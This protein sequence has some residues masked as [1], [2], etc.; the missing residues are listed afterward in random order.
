MYISSICDFILL[1]DLE[2]EQATVSECDRSNN[3]TCTK[4]PLT[5]ACQVW[6]VHSVLYYAEYVHKSTYPDYWLINENVPRCGDSRELLPFCRPSR[7]CSIFDDFVGRL[8][9]YRSTKVF[10]CCHGDCLPWKT[11]IYFSYLFCLLFHLLDVWCKY[12]FAVLK[13]DAS[14]I[15]RSAFCC[16][17]SWYRMK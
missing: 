11:N 17:A 13:G 5:D 15:L 12:H 8:L 1:T 2:E 4:K 6:L 10:L 14:I 16:C 9:A 3:E 7:T